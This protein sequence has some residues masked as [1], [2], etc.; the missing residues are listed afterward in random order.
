MSNEPEQIELRLHYRV[1]TQ[2]VDAESKCVVS[3]A[4]KKYQLHQK[5]TLEGGKV[6]VTADFDVG[7]QAERDESAVPCLQ[8]EMRSGGEFLILPDRT[9]L[10]F[11]VTVNSQSELKFSKENVIKILNGQ[12]ALNNV[13]EVLVLIVERQNTWTVSAHQVIPVQ[14]QFRALAHS[15]VEVFVLGNC[16]ELCQQTHQN[17][18]VADGSGVKLQGALRVRL[19]CLGKSYTAYRYS[20]QQI[21]TS[22]TVNQG[23]DKSIRTPDGDPLKVRLKVNDE[24]NELHDDMPS[25][26]VPLSCESSESMLQSS[27]FIVDFD[28][29]GVNVH[30]IVNWR[31]SFFVDG[32]EDQVTDIRLTGLCETELKLSKKEN[33]AWHTDCLLVVATAEDCRGDWLLKTL[34][35][36]Y[37]E[38]EM[39]V[40]VEEK[41]EKTKLKM[42]LYPRVSKVWLNTKFEAHVTLWQNKDTNSEFSESESS[43]PPIFFSLEMRQF[44]CDFLSWRRDS[45][46]KNLFDTVTRETVKRQLQLERKPI[47]FDTVK[48]IYAQLLVPLIK[49]DGSYDGRT[50]ETSGNPSKWHNIWGEADGTDSVGNPNQ[51]KES[52][53]QCVHRIVSDS[54][55]TVEEAR[56]LVFNRLRKAY[57]NREKKVYELLGVT[58]DLD[59]V[60]EEQLLAAEQHSKSLLEHAAAIVRGRMEAALVLPKK[61]D[62]ESHVGEAIEWF[63]FL[64][65]IWCRFRHQNPSGNEPERFR[66]LITEDQKSPSDIV[67]ADTKIYTTKDTKASSA[68][69]DRVKIFSKFT[70][71]LTRYHL[72]SRGL[73]IRF[74]DVKSTYAQLLVPLIKKDGSYDGRTKK[75]SGNPSK[76]HNIWGEADGTDPVGNPNQ[77]KESAIQCVHRIV[78]DSTLNVE[79]A[80]NLVF[81]RLQ[82]TYINREENVFKLLGVT[83]DLN[84]VT[85]QQ[86]LAAEQ[87]YKSL[88]EHAAAI[89]RGRMEA[90]LVLPMETDRESHVGEATE[91]FVF[92]MRVWWRF[93]KLNPSGDEQY[94]FRE[95]ITEVQKSPADVVAAGTLTYSTK[96]TKAS[97][98]TFDRVEILNEFTN[99]LTRYHLS[100]RGSP[101]RFVD[102]KST[103]AQLLVP[104]IKKDGSYD[105]R[106]KETSGNP[107]RWHNIWGEADGT[108]SVG[109]P[110]QTKESA[111]QCVHRIVSDS[112]LN[113]EEARNS[114]FTR[115]R[116][117]YSIRGEKVFELLGV[118]EDLDAVTEEQLLAAEQHYKSLLEHAAAIVRGR[119][120]AA[121]VLPK[122]TDRESHMGEATE[123]FVFLMRVWCRFRQL[124]PSGDEQE[125]FRESISEPSAA[126]AS[127]SDPDSLKPPEKVQ[128]LLQLSFQFDGNAVRERAV[129]EFD[130]ETFSTSKI[131]KVQ[132]AQRKDAVWTRNGEAIKFKAKTKSSDEFE[133]FQLACSEDFNFVEEV[134][135]YKIIVTN[136][137]QILRQM[138]DQVGERIGDFV[139]KVCKGEVAV[140]QFT[141]ITLRFK[142]EHCEGMSAVWVSNLS[143]GNLHL[144][145]DDQKREWQS[146]VHVPLV[147]IDSKQNF[148]VQPLV[149]AVINN[150]LYNCSLSMQKDKPDGAQLVTDGA[151][152]IATVSEL[153]TEDKKWDICECTHESEDSLMPVEVH[154]RVRGKLENRTVELISQKGNS[155]TAGESMSV[156]TRVLPDGSI[157]GLNELKV[158]IDEQPV[159]VEQK[160]IG[161]TVSKVVVLVYLDCSQPIAHI[162]PVIDVPMV[163]SAEEEGVHV[164]SNCPELGHEPTSSNKL[165]KDSSAGRWVKWQRLQLAVINGE[166]K[167]LDGQPVTVWRRKNRKKVHHWPLRLLCHNSAAS[168]IGFSIQFNKDTAEP[169]VHRSVRT[170]LQIRAGHQEGMTSLCAK[171]VVLTDSPFSYESEPCVIHSFA[172]EGC[173]DCSSKDREFWDGTV[174]LAVAVPVPTEGMGFELRHP[175]GRSLEFE[176]H[177]EKSNK[178]KR[179]PVHFVLKVESPIQHVAFFCEELVYKNPVTDIEKREL[180][181]HFSKLAKGEGMFQTLKERFFPENDS[182]QPNCPPV[183]L[184]DILQM[185]EEP[186]SKKAKNTATKMSPRNAKNT[187]KINDKL[188]RNPELSEEFKLRKIV[189][190]LLVPRFKRCGAYA[191]PTCDNPEFHTCIWASVKDVAKALGE[192]QQR[193]MENGT[194]NDIEEDKLQ[195]LESFLRS[196]KLFEPRCFKLN[197]A[198]ACSSSAQYL[199]RRVEHPFGWQH[200]QNDPLGVNA[201]LA[202]KQIRRRLRTLYHLKRQ[203]EIFEKLNIDLEGINDY[204]DIVPLLWERCVQLRNPRHLLKPALE[205]LFKFLISTAAAI[206]RG[207]AEAHM[208]PLVA[209]D[210]NHLR[211]AVAWLECTFNA[212]REYLRENTQSKLDLADEIE[213]LLKESNCPEPNFYN[214]PC[215]CKL[216][217]CKNNSSPK[218]PRK[219]KK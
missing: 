175:D 39:T 1:E 195:K 116:K 136:K 92:L 203:R 134:I 181:E 84:A 123:W 63:V 99:A 173:K 53:I 12:H 67:A 13:V 171:G 76:W 204:F 218:K 74:V 60:T 33:S 10:E 79:D 182:N 189:F 54:T 210:E 104:L 140:E 4:G 91:W 207:R 18:M 169:M 90:A 26:T 191:E 138:P 16:E 34:D 160:L 43:D 179:M 156:A 42:S 44:D 201:T 147:Y 102:V 35:G 112:T 129:V 183:S 178:A 73:P 213:G 62:R 81:N 142:V 98:P 214:W 9:P 200:L 52:A 96:D 205:E 48:S 150:K 6:F 216:P 24:L 37:F 30:Q 36:E 153:P 110:N 118:T 119:M 164:L 190:D 68:A 87:H 187:K 124:D 29:V 72:S 105:G 93:R 139:V 122:K 75:T 168:E 19:A 117:T 11:A 149:Q 121:L 28:H 78:S 108:D 208:L 45:V 100:S 145:L 97:S 58:E 83:E 154:L 188:K 198:V 167:I 126:S 88:L 130:G 103:Y 146:P 174:E 64:M 162:L 111:I 14:L 77:T 163:F 170:L 49:K 151:D 46:L 38:C 157:S 127:M 219:P 94:R 125:R 15:G 158:V 211:A 172:K 133:E 69:F 56:N 89:V 59:A 202:A 106:T 20:D 2:S 32:L 192:L 71:A 23:E 196:E 120:E 212:F 197:D 215:T 85:E 161:A 21:E 186:T 95:S 57:S 209:T 17:R 155:V 115:L 31:V 86:L 128:Q 61:T 113:V 194:V 217:C 107:S 47:D 65:R 199:L 80:R 137:V 27:G 82:K 114:V 135:S 148:K 5:D 50:K 3:L 185:K 193:N 206:A 8:A 7:L 166:F 131:V 109:N 101:I 132:D 184:R 141:S 143:I 176:L 144:R 51:T 159:A 177:A 70:N 66:E 22:E 55:L 165:T 40:T 41:P 152:L 180:E 25:Q